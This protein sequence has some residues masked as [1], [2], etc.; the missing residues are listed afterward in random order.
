MQKEYV[1]CIC[2]INGGKNMMRFEEEFELLLKCKTP[3]IEV[4]TFEW[5]RLQSLL[6]KI[7]KENLV[8]WKRWNRSIGIIDQDGNIEP[9]MD[10]LKLLNKFKDENEEY[11]LILENFNLYLNNSDVINLLFEICKMKRNKQKSLI[12]ESSEAC[13]PPAL[14]KEIVLLNMPLPNRDFI[15]KIA[16][17]VIINY[18]LQA[19][20]YCITPELLNSVLGLTTTEANLAFIKAVEKYRKLDNSAINYLISEKEHI[21]KKDG[22]L[23]YYHT[24]ES[25]DSVGGLTNLKSG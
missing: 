21:I 17:S 16:E 19:T 20:E 10:P 11:Y 1:E 4:V 18:G 23:E 2:A 12:I 14:S 5:Q 15:K 9:I 6:N 13:L 7:A 22:L 24:D 25:M 3:I 8:K